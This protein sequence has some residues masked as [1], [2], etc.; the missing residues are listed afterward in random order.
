MV[1]SHTFLK[2]TPWLSNSKH[3]DP[4]YWHNLGFITSYNSTIP[5]NISCA[6]TIYDFNFCNTVNLERCNLIIFDFISPNNSTIQLELK[7]PVNC[8]RHLDHVCRSSVSTRTLSATGEEHVT[9]SDPLLVSGYQPSTNNHSSLF[10]NR[11]PSSLDV[12]VSVS[13]DARY[14]WRMSTRETV[15]SLEEGY[16][17]SDRDIDQLKIKTSTTNKYTKT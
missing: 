9:T 5:L 17:I 15:T 7:V 2:P 3:N 13:A 10:L 16:R 11:R 12:F 6:K 1:S 14:V 8:Y 4:I